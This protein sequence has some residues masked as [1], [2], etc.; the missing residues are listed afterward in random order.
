MRKINLTEKQLEV[1][2]TEYQ[3][4]QDSAEHYD[5]LFWTCFGIFLTLF[6]G[7]LH[8]IMTKTLNEIEQIRII[9]IMIILI[10]LFWP[11]LEQFRN[12]RNQKYNRCKK[13]E[14][15]L[16]MNQHLTTENNNQTWWRRKLGSQM[17]MLRLIMIIILIGLIS[18]LI[19][20]ISG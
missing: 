3:K 20:I 18:G 1:S 15:I 6:S 16:P 13:I 17:E 12:Y 5:T 10:I 11:C 19:K 7:T 4:S 8:Y 14:R 9:Y 2:L